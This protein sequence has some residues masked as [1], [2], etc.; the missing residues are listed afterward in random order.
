MVGAGAI[1]RHQGRGHASD[2][3]RQASPSGCGCSSGAHQHEACPLPARCAVVLPANVLHRTTT[4]ASSSCASSCRI[5]FPPNGG[6][7]RATAGGS[8]VG[9]KKQAPNAQVLS[10][11]LEATRYEVLRSFLARVAAA[12]LRFKEEGV[13]LA[14]LL[15]EL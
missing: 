4:G 5:A 1:R 13:A 12:D 8:C 3:R 11:R 6:V 15:G 10:Q 2:R 7:L 9:R 14:L